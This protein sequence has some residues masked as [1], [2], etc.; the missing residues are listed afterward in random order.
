MA[1]KITRLNYP[2]GSELKL[3]K[4]IKNSK[5]IISLEEIKDNLCFWGCIALAE[6]SRLD[7]YIGQTKKIFCE[8]YNTKIT[9]EYKGFDYVNELDKYEEFNKKY[10]INIV[11]YY[12]DKTLEYVRRS[13]FNTKRTPIYLNLYLEHFSYIRSLEKLCK[14]YICNRCGAKFRDNY[15][16]EKH[17]DTCDLEQKDT[18]VKYSE[19]YEKKRNNIVELCD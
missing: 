5:L 16:L 4:Y 10:A 2:I 18:F 17:I 11:K 15:K 1:V 12:E 19:V 6:G 3:P 14:M 9:K 7:A 13:E 8:F